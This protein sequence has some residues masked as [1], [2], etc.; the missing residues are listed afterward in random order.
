MNA[1]NTIYSSTAAG[2]NPDLGAAVESLIHQQRDGS[3]GFASQASVDAQLDPLEGID[4]A[5]LH[6]CSTVERLGI[7]MLV[8]VLDTDCGASCNI[9][10]GPPLQRL[11]GLCVRA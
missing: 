4:L 8:P 1:Y 6:R 11:F 2:R 10:A 5:P 3:P 7:Q 9:C